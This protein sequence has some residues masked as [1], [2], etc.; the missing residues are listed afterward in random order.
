[1]F[2]FACAYRVYGGIHF[3]KSVTNG[4]QL[5]LKVS[6]FVNNGLATL[7]KRNIAVDSKQTISAFF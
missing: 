7:E 3:L 5:G 2:E 6:F 4:T 1:M